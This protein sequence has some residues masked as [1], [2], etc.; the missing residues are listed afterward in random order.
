VNPTIHH[1]AGRRAITKDH[2]AVLGGCMRP[3]FRRALGGAGAPT[4][5]PSRSEWRIGV[6]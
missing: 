2:R 3:T 4:P 6:L 5:M 1:P